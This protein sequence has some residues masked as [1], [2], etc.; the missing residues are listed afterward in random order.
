MIRYRAKGSPMALNHPF[1]G[2]IVLRDRG[3][4]VAFPARSFVDLV[5]SPNIPGARGAP[6]I[7]VKPHDPGTGSLPSR[8]KLAVYE[9]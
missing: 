5:K 4:T 1:V 6:C 9:C 7:A 3:K 8:A 2:I